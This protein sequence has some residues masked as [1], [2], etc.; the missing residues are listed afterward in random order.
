MAQLLPNK[1]DECPL[2][3]HDIVSFSFPKRNVFM[4]GKGFWRNQTKLYS[5][6]NYFEGK[7]ILAQKQINFIK[8]KLMHDKVMNLTMGDTPTKSFFEKLKEKKDNLEPTKLF[9]DHGFLEE[10]P[11]K[12]VHVAKEF[13]ENK[14]MPQVLEAQPQS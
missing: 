1:H 7:Q 6:E 9:T 8:N 3:D 4:K 12:L 13:F 10:N 14:F 5:F 2:S 11:S